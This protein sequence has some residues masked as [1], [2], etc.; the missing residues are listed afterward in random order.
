MSMFLCAI[1]DNIKDSDDGCHE[2]IK[3]S[4]TDFRLVCEDCQIEREEE[5]QSR[6]DALL[7]KADEEL[8]R[9]REDGEL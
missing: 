5:T 6:E 8:H 9:R 1:C 4:R 7:D 2:L 3:D